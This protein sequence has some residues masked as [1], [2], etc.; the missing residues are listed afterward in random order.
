[1]SRNVWPVTEARRRSEKPG[2]GS[3]GE[4]RSE[5]MVGKV[6]MRASARVVDTDVVWSE[7]NWGLRAMSCD[8]GQSKDSRRGG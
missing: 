3:G 7:V 8:V 2:V 5:D 1:M 6:W 4:L